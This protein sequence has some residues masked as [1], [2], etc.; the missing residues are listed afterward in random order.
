[1]DCDFAF[2]CD[3]AQQDR[4]LHAI[5]I[6][7]DVIYAAAIPVVHPTMTFVASLR[8]SIAEKGTKE[9]GVRLIDADGEDVVPPVEQQM[10]FEVKPGQLE[11][12]ANVILQFTGVQF[13]KY[14]QYAIHLTVQDNEMKSVPFRVAEMPQTA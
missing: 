14:G 2:L 6:G 1:M 9:I 8:G 10:P 12:R 3:F 11:A 7:W 4:K 5:G 13:K